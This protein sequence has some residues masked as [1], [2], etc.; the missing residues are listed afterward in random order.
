M[1]RFCGHPPFG[2]REF[3]RVLAGP[4]Y[5]RRLAAQAVAAGVSIR[6]GHSVV[7]LEPGP[8]LR[9]ATRDGASALD[10]Q[11][12]ACSPRACARRRAPPA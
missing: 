1:P 5:A 11:A 8:R 12:R 9:L 7:A 3:G 2:M 6:T 10:G 4:A